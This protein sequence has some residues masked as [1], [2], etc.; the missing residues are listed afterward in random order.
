M[1]NDL[2]QKVNNGSFCVL[3]WIHDFRNL[4]GRKY[5]CCVSHTSRQ[6]LPEDINS[7]EHQELRRQ[8][9]TGERAPHCAP[10]YKLEDNNVVSWR[11]STNQEWLGKPAIREYFE[12]WDPSVPP[13]LSYYD[14]RYNSKCNL[15]CI[16]CS[17]EFS[18]LWKKELGIPIT[19][20]QLDVDPAAV[21][22]SLKVYMAGGEPLIIDEYVDLLKYLALNDY[23]GLVSINTNLTSLKPD[24]VDAIKAIKNVSLIVSVDS[25]GNTEEYHR[26]PKQWNKFL[27]NLA[28]LADNHIEYN[29]NT[30]AS[31]ISVLG[32]SRMPELQQYSPKNWWLVPLETPASLR[33][34]NLPREIKSQTRDIISNMQQVKFYE[35]DLKFR[36]S[37]DHLIQRV[38]LQGNFSE[39]KRHINQ[40]DTR[41]NIDHASYLGINLFDY[42]DTI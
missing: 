38:S 23:Q 16:T 41:R 22:Q 13:R 37:L 21:L 35:S 14:L 24:V 9:W 33:L 39:L 32:W 20:Y 42:K 2:T 10:C 17:P 12:N 26:Y 28:V 8:L 19:E 3:P 11:H 34:E 40:L 6:T 31:A 7:P 4:D 15:S 36:S 27:D 30:V 29:F 25:W 1:K 18:T 5:A